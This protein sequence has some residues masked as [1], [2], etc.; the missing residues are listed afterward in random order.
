MAVE[1]ASA[2][3]SLHRAYPREFVMPSVEAK[4]DEIA[5]VAARGPEETIASLQSG[6]ARRIYFASGGG[7]TMA[8]TRRS[9]ES[10]FKPN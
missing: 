5:S 1:K 10:N 4:R 8:L 9:C 3:A 6:H 7:P 2:N